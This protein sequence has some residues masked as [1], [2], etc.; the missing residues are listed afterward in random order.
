M[1]G[2]E[3]KGRSVF[4]KAARLLRRYGY[5]S[6]LRHIREDG[7]KATIAKTVFVPIRWCGWGRSWLAGLVFDHRHGLQTSGY[8]PLEDLAREGLSVEESHSHLPTPV[9]V[10]P[11]ILSRLDIDYRT[12]T[13]VDL[14]SGKGAAILSA[15]E[16]GFR[17]IIGVEFS[18]DL[19]ATSMEN[20][21]KYR[22]QRDLQSEIE[23]MN[24][25]ARDFEF[26]E[27]EILLYVFNPFENTLLSIIFDRLASSYEAAPRR[28]ILVYLNVTK[29]INPRAIIAKLGFMTEI[30]VF[31]LLETARFYSKC[32]FP[33][34]V[35]TTKEV[36]AIALRDPS[37]RRKAVCP[38]P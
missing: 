10:I 33:V 23:V 18:K 25:D 8:V 27:T 34:M 31:S 29:K 37:R 17:R 14:G 20:V 24:M 19:H 38:E 35:W 2:R 13:F 15:A 1:A 26:P 30:R 12:F 16:F 4:A 7:L 28:I 6:I 9:N 36:G 5:T 3:T 22:R 21:R 32:P 11:D